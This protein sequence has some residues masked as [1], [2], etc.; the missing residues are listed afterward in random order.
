MCQE[1]CQAQR[2]KEDTVLV[3]QVVGYIQDSEA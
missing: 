3:V 1:R 2:E